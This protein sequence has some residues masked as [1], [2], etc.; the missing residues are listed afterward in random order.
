MVR[1]SPPIILVKGKVTPLHLN[2]GCGV[3]DNSSG[4][5][6]S[7]LGEALVLAVIHSFILLLRRGGGEREW[8]MDSRDACAEASVNGYQVLST[9]MS[10]SPFACNFVRSVQLIQFPAW[11]SAHGFVW[12]SGRVSQ[13]GFLVKDSVLET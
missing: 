11:C 10:P 13:S 6:V 3:S 1:E 4:G 12:G 2:L 8:F 7:E 5:T 9:S